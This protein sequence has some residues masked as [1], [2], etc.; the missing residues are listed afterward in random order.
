MEI[1]V[2]ILDSY[3]VLVFELMNHNEI[4]VMYD[5]SIVNCARKNEWKFTLV[6]F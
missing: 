5:N 1:R 3:K 2:G 4:F 6:L